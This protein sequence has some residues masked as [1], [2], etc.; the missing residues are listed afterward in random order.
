MSR[1]RLC[2]TPGWNGMCENAWGH[3]T[4]YPEGERKYEFC[5][6]IFP[7]MRCSCLVEEPEKKKD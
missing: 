4:C 3:Y 6:D 2:D 1:V 7:V 5:T